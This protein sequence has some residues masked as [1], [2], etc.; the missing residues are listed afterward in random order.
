MNMIV[1]STRF[2][3]FECP[4]DC[5][6]TFKGGILGFPQGERYVILQ[7]KEESPFRWLQSVEEPALAF[8]VTDPAN[9]C[10]DYA[11]EMPTSI[12]EELQLNENTPRMVYVILTI[13]PGKPEEMTANLAG[14][15][16]INAETRTGKQI[17]LQDERWSTKHR[18]LGEA[19]PSAYTPAA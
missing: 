9:F 11:P 15:L 1:H 17:V 18:V 14:P 12:A 6:V 4:E 13:P 19:V 7:H 5:I 10:P 3:T 2:G 8:L 16:L